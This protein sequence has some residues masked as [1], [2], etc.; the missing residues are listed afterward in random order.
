MG[1]DKCYYNVLVVIDLLW[2]LAVCSVFV[3][4]LSTCAG[5]CVENAG[6]CMCV[7]D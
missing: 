7:K 3:L 6:F 5:D 2:R 4:C 1:C